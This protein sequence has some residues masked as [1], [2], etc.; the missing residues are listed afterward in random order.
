M[1]TKGYLKSSKREE[2]FG[3]E[4]CVQACGQNAIS[5]Q[6][7]QEGFRYPL[8]NQKLCVQCG[9]CYNICPS[10]KLSQPMNTPQYICGGYSLKEDIRYAS[11]S[12]GIF[13][14]IV[15]VFCDQDYAI[16][17]AEAKGLDVWHSFVTDKNEIDRYRKSKYSQSKIGD[18][19]KYAKRLLKKGMKVL[20]SGTPCQIAGLQNYLQG[21]D[22]KKL[23]TV[24]VVCE[25]VPTPLYMRKYE[26]SLVR[27][28]GQEIESIDYRFT[29]KGSLSKGRW[30]F[31]VMRIVLKNLNKV[32]KLDRWFNPFW[33]LWIGHMMS[34]PSC[35]QC[36]FATEKRSADITLGDLWGVHLYCPE[37]Y[38][39]N[40]GSSLMTAN[41][42]KGEEVLLEVQ[43]RIYGHELKLEDAIKYQGPMRKSADAHP[44][45]S[46]LMQDLQSDMSYEEINKKWAP[47]ITFKLWWQK[48]IWGNRQ[49]I[50]LWK[51]T[52]GKYHIR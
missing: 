35:Y 8:L 51:L 4:A 27:K 50:L 41:S 19:Y 52:G 7:D 28:Y 32:I 22:C 39:S 45:R 36:P 5:M 30:D 1:V 24:E 44:K 29:D 49:K 33:S 21:S 46:L 23:L 26:K 11:T 43:K 17:G 20:F 15:D 2:C 18:S 3:C 42:D 9:I 12:G 6:E 31:Q 34:R 16:F 38:G 10:T 37:L 14:E 47:K 13:S 48:Y 40:Q 25:G